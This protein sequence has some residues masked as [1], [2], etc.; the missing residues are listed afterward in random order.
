MELGVMAMTGVYIIPRDPEMV[1]HNKIKHNG[2]LPDTY[3]GVGSYSS[4]RDSQYI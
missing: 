2:I 1:P 4:G 3:S